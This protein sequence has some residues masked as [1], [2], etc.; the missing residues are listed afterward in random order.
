[1]KKTFL[2]FIVLGFAVSVQAQR[3][4]LSVEGGANYTYI[5]DFATTDFLYRDNNQLY[6]PIIELNHQFKG[7]AGGRMQANMH[8]TLTPKVKLYYAAGLTLNRFN[9]TVSVK[10]PENSEIGT[11]GPFGDWVVIGEGSGGILLPEVLGM[12]MTI[13]EYPNDDR[14]GNTSLV[15]LN[16]QIGAHYAIDNR[17]SVNTGL[18]VNYLV[19]ARQHVVGYRYNEETA[20]SESFVYQ[21]KSRKYFSTVAFEF[22]AGISYQIISQLGINLQA[23]KS[24]T[25]VYQDSNREARPATLSLGLAYKLKSW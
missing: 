16:Q 14:I 18:A 10:V 6:N 13:P 12:D 11:D 1:M 3:L 23:R 21:E 22:D 25:S 17:W 9:Y 15:Y 7:K 19:V 8:Y 20:A 4:E 24:L 5:S 2:L